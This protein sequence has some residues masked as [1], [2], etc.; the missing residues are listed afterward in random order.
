MELH[1]NIGD[2]IEVDALRVGERPRRG[3]VVEVITQGEHIHYRVR[4]E[5]G[6]ESTFFPAATAH[7]VHHQQDR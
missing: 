1:A 7:V 3:E 4:W 6:H 2:T 5:D